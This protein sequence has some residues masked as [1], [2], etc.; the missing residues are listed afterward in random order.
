MGAVLY[1]VDQDW[2]E[3]RHLDLRGGG[4][5]AGPGER[6]GIWIEGR[7]AD[8]MLRHVHITDCR[9]SGIRGDLG[10]R[11]CGIWVALPSWGDSGGAPAKLSATD[12]LIARND[13][14]SVSRAGIIVLVAGTAPTWMP[15]PVE[16]VEPSVKSLKHLGGRKFEVAYEWQVNDTFDKDV[17]CFVHI[18]EAGGTAWFQNDHALPVPTSQWR[19]G[20]TVADGP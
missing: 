19:P 12:V 6:G 1:L 10:Y 9:V 15:G 11:S 13:V 8:R 4:D 7:T 5:G 14:R 16:Q 2:W 20:M 17:I 3:I 18:T